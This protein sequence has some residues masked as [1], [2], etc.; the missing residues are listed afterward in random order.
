[1][2]I[3][4]IAKKYQ[5]YYRN[6]RKQK[7]ISRSPVEQL[8]SEGEQP[9]NIEKTSKI[10]ANVNNLNHQSMKTEED[11][12]I[13]FNS[14]YKYLNSIGV[15][16][17]KNEIMHKRKI[18]QNLLFG[19]FT[20]KENFDDYLKSTFKKVLPDSQR[21]LSGKND[22]PFIFKSELPH[23]DAFTLFNCPRIK[24]SRNKKEIR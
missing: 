10:I 19:D 18:K 21:K 17:T 4:D 16:S 14:F 6:A 20:T 9:K 12:E 5:K 23:A 11:V 24:I 8:K 7:S 3:S 22:V 2:K 15:R 1:M 13:H